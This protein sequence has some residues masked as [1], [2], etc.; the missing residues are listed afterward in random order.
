VRGDGGGRGQ[1]G[2]MAQ[3]VYAYMHKKKNKIMSFEGKQM[4][5][6]IIILSEVSQI[7]KDKH[8]MFSCTC[9]HVEPRKKE[10]T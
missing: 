8:G 2:E 5:L 9:A 6:E 10:Q 4:E 7:Q 1:G 3:T